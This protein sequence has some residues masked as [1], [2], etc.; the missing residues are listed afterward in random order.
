MPGAQEE[1]EERE[2]EGEDSELA[3]NTLLN[4]APQTSDFNPDSGDASGDVSG[5]A[6]PAFSGSRPDTPSYSHSSGSLPGT[7]GSKDDGLEPSWPNSQDSGSEAPPSPCSLPCW[8]GA[9]PPSGTTG[10]SLLHWQAESDLAARRA[11][12]R[13]WRS[14]APADLAATR[15]ALR[16]QSAGVGVWLRPTVE[17]LRG[18]RPSLPLT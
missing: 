3:R 17:A 12:F 7:P 16:Q 9:P 14:E 2:K 6:S 10:C 11:A 13:A 8:A 15:A 5:D 4:A 1:E 18:L